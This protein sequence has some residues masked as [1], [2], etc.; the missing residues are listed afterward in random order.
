V[1]DEPPIQQLAAHRADP[2]CGD[3]VRP[4]HLHRGAQDADALAGEHAST[5][6]VNLLSRSRMKNVN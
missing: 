2:S 5:V 1:D 3:R 4:R 6:S